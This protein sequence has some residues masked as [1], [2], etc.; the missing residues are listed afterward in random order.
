MELLLLAVG[1]GLIAYA[2]YKWATLNNDYFTV[3]YPTLPIAAPTF[4]IGSS[5]GM[6]MGL[7][8]MDTWCRWLY[9]IHP[10]AR[11]IGMFAF[12]QPMILLRDP[13]LIKQVCVAIRYDRR[14]Y[15]PIIMC[16]SPP[17]GGRQRL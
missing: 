10:K 5:G 4:L 2:F 6:M 8:H 1:I 15:I 12:R 3:N 13:E 14:F 16:T 17:T 11:A 7:H 9:N